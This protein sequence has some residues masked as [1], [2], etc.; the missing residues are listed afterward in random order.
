M[1]AE[2]NKIASGSQRLDHKVFER[3]L[4]QM[5]RQTDLVKKKD[6]DDM[7]SARDTLE[8]H[9]QFRGKDHVDITKEGQKAAQH[10]GVLQELA[11][12]K[13]TKKKD[14]VL[15]TKKAKVSKTD[16]KIA[17]LKDAI[18][19]AKKAAESEIPPPPE[20]DAA[21]GAKAGP[22]LGE[23]GTAPAGKV[24]AKDGKPGAAPPAG[25]LPPAGMYPGP[26]RLPG[27]SATQAAT[28]FKATQDD[29]EGAS[30]IFVQM[31]A[32]RQKWF[33]DI[34]KIFA[35]LQTHIMKTVQDVMANRAAVMD[36]I[37]EK[38]SRVMRGTY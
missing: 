10:S 16:E 6:V 1:S 37:N 7:A 13:K 28:R 4:Q 17:G 18:K 27:E 12:D 21:K 14:K 19:D 32:N 8:L 3:N 29:L 36:K 25:T 15:D 22:K 11:G 38:W 20:F 35:D 24:A 2:I 9:D 26:G 31:A 30:K 33:M 23:A 5:G 34:W